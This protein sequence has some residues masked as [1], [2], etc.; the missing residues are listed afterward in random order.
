MKARRLRFAM[1]FGTATEP[2]CVHLIGGEDV[3]FSLRAPELEQWLP[4]LLQRLAR[5]ESDAVLLGSLP[6]HRRAAARELVDQLVGERVL[7]V[8]ASPRPAGRAWSLEVDGEGRLAER[9]RAALPIASA[10]GERLALICQ[11]ALDYR[12][13]RERS[14]ELRRLGR[15]HVWASVGPISRALVSPLFLPDASPCFECLLSHFLRLSR[16]PDVTRA[17]FTSGLESLDAPE[18]SER[19]L[20]LV[21]ELVAFK[22][23]LAAEP[24]PPAALFR[25]HAFELCTLECSS[26]PVSPN[27]ECSACR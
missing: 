14:A 21:A 26:H 13:A 9:V 4:P 20:A 19:G 18:F 23:A 24:E 10:A 16:A 2:D 5:G 6:E 12:A 7:V 11:D 27:P 1:P 22:C 8:D 15:A 25:L 17:L 3:R